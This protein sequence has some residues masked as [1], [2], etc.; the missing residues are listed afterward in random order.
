MREKNSPSLGMLFQK[1]PFEVLEIDPDRI[2]VVREVARLEEMRGHDLIACSYRLR[3][4][5][6]LGADLYRDLTWVKKALEKHGYAAEAAVADA[7]FGPYPS[8]DERC[9]SIL[10][11][12]L[13]NQR[14]VPAP[15][16]FEFIDDRR[17]P[18]QP[19]VA[20]IVSLYN[21]AAKLLSRPG[22]VIY[23]DQG[24]LVEGNSPFQVAWLPDERREKY[25]ERVRTRET[26]GRNGHP[27]AIVR[28]RGRPVSTSGSPSRTRGSP[29]SSS[30]TLRHKRCRK[31]WLPTTARVSQGFDSSMVNGPVE[32][33]QWITKGYSGQFARVSIEKLM[34]YAL[35]RGLEYQDMPLVRRIASDVAQQDNRFS[36]IVLA[37]GRPGQRSRCRRWPGR[38]HASTIAENPETPPG[39][40]GHHRQARGRNP[41]AA[42]PA[43][44]GQPVELGAGFR[45]T[46]QLRALGRAERR[47]PQQREGPDV[48]GDVLLVL[49]VHAAR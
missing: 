36:A 4:M 12:A 19:R 22:E 29:V 33:R 25:L 26:G 8:R 45:V 6:W 41:A 17:P 28:C 16:R 10:Q 37:C 31:R 2:R 27:A 38:P 46:E 7:M 44:G 21:A 24:G 1:K 15:T 42:A 30:M 32:L 47:R 9:L 39:H 18:G 13:E 5:R 34:T 49:Q 14:A 35:G 43:R 11:E 40:P 3:I 23:N 48:A 20:I